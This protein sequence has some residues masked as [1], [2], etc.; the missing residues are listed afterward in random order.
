MSLIYILDLLGTFVFASTGAIR[1]LEK[2]LDLFGIFVLSFITAVGGGTIRDVILGSRPF[3]FFDVNY[4]I[5]ILLGM[6]LVIFIRNEVKRYQ[7]ILVYLDALG[8]GTFSVIGSI[9]AIESSIPD[10]GVLIS[11]LITGIGGGIIRDILV[12]EVPFVLEK[13]IYATASI[14]GVTLFL[15]LERNNLLPTSI[16]VWISIFVIFG[17]R[18][19]TYHLKVNLP[20][21]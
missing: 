13:E 16:S 14:A 9:K 8:L 6:L 12:R 20:K 4:S 15:I 11:G 7:Q 10:V 1:A 17:I 19:F 2:R 18:V 5:A 21:F 3:Y